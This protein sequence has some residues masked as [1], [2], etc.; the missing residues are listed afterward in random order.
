MGDKLG[1]AKEVS[2]KPSNVLA[3]K[4]SKVF[5]SDNFHEPLN[6]RLSLVDLETT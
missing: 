1:A 6:A 4:H 2:A 3:H 5:T